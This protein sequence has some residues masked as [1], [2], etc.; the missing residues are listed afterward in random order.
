MLSLPIAVTLVVINVAYSKVWVAANLPESV[1]QCRNTLVPEG[2]TKI[3]PLGP[4]VIS[5]FGLV[6]TQ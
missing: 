4:G 6:S 1:S 3:D 2:G 5:D